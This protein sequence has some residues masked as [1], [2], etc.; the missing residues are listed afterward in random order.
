MEKVEVW[1]R[2]MLNHVCE[3]TGYTADDP[4]GWGIVD[5]DLSML[6]CNDAW[7][8]M[9][10]YTLNEVQSMTLHDFWLTDEFKTGVLNQDRIKYRKYV[11]SKNRVLTC[12]IEVN[13]IPYG[14]KMI[15]TGK[16]L[17]WEYQDLTSKQPN[18]KTMWD[19]V[20][21]MPAVEAN[22]QSNV[23][24]NIP[25]GIY[26][27]S[28]NQYLLFVNDNFAKTL[29]YAKEEL[30][31]QKNTGELRGPFVTTVDEMA[32]DIV[33]DYQPWILRAWKHKKGGW[34]WGRCKTTKLKWAGMTGL[35]H[36]VDWIRHDVSLLTS[37]NAEDIADLMGKEVSLK[38]SIK[39][40]TKL[41]E[42]YG[43]SSADVVAATYLL[44][45]QGS[46]TIDGE[47]KPEE[48]QLNLFENLK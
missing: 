45:D 33:G 13:E 41:A 19:F 9:F 6:W 35:F 27:T 16:V 23:L 15:Y 36:V 20:K 30:V 14:N 46:I 25:M 2:H 47:G 32:K 44:R 43:V 40:L 48:P 37:I 8:K 28:L 31:L 39:T 21:R 7:N 12:K 18:N 34:Q 17:R 26:H 22:E 42:F 24:D 11:D 10:G 38:L 4:Q 1:N 3:A 29:G 5:Q